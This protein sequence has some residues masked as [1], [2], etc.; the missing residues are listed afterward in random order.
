MG[1][2]VHPK[3]FRLSTIRTWDSLWFSKKEF[4]RL[5]QED[6]NIR[7]FLEKNLKEAGVDHIRIERSL[8][9]IH[10]TIVAA[11]PGFIIGRAG[12]GI[13]DLRKKLMRALFP[14]KRIHLALNVKEV[15]RP[16]LSARIVGQQIATELE[17]RMPF[18][19]CMKG[20]IDRVMKAGA[21]GVKIIV[22]GRLNGAEIARREKLTSGKVPLQNLRAD[23]D[24]AH[25]P[26]FTIFGTIGVRVWIYRGEVF[27]RKPEEKTT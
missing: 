19:T 16:M 24:F 17:R 6:H 18:R 7:A 22:S 20:A 21:E 13:E 27:D 11:K 8:Q 1:T 25:V 4:P 2:K 14:G 23:I 3:A 15:T 10:V 9:Q 5:L 26:A 12:A